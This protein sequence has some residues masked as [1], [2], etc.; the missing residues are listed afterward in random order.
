M[1]KLQMARPPAAVLPF[2]WL[3]WA[4]AFASAATHQMHSCAILSCGEAKCRGSSN[5]AT[6]SLTAVDVYCIGSGLVAI[7]LHSCGIRALLLAGT[8]R[9]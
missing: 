1:A 9:S 3:V 2:P 4:A 8:A 7:A 5:W 6:V